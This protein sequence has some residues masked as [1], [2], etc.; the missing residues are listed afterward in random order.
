MRS[1]SWEAALELSHPTYRPFNNLLSKPLAGGRGDALS[2][3]VRRGEPAAP[4]A[5]SGYSLEPTA[6]GHIAS[7]RRILMLFS[8][9]VPEARASFILPAS[10]RSLYYMVG[11]PKCFLGCVTHT[12]LVWFVIVW[13]PSPTPGR[14]PSNLVF[15]W[16]LGLGL[17]VGGRCPS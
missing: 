16:G 9:K 7:Y 10:P 3:C 4:P 15:P 12:W 1:L 2:A 13:S 8:L 11:P 5:R 6:P 17:H 14:E